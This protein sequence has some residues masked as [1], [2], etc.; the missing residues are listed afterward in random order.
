MIDISCNA[1]ISRSNKLVLHFA[2][3]GVIIM[4]IFIAPVKTSS[5]SVWSTESNFD[6]R[7]KLSKT[8]GRCRRTSWKSTFHTPNDQQ[9]KRWLPVVKHMYASFWYY[10]KVS[11]RR[12]LKRPIFNTNFM[13]VY[14][15]KS[16]NG[17]RILNVYIYVRTH[18]RDKIV[19]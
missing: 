16:L 19:I 12:S 11:D 2:S 13:Y 10:R 17:S 4:T 5:I 14:T 15:Y 3:Q 9:N 7:S 6:Q 18:G 8:W 1:S